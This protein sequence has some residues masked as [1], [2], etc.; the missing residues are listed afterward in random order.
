MA[1]FIEN[2]SGAISEVGID[3]FQGGGVEVLF[4]DVNDVSD[5]HARILLG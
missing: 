2:D 3:P 1:D 5:F 4:A